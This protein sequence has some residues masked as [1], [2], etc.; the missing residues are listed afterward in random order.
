MDALGMSSIYDKL[1]FVDESLALKDFFM[2]VFYISF[3]KL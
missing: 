1:T 2:K 3:G